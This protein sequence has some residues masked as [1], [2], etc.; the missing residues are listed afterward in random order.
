MSSMKGAMRA[1]T[2]ARSYAA[3][4]SSRWRLP[5]WC[6][7]LGRVLIVATAAGTIS[8]S[9]RAPR[10]PSS[11]SRLIG[12]PRAANRC[13]GAESSAI[14]RRTGLPV[15]STSFRLKVY[16]KAA[17]TRCARGA[18]RR[19]VLPA[20]EFCSWIPRGLRNSHA[21]DNDAGAA[22]T[23]ERQREALGRQRAHVHAH[24]DEGLQAEPHTEP[25]RQIGA[26]A[27]AA[28]LRAM[29]DHERA[30]HQQRE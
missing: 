20:M 2:P 9:A 22:V 27:V 1:L 7:M 11:T 26:E 17:H 30:P 28:Q 6:Q 15:C 14:S 16:G 4:A 8:L 21:H 25:I 3:R 18:S 29:T 13:A 19:F 5:V 24:V 23:H 10:L 12:P